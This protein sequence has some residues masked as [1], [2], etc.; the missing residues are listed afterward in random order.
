MLQSIRLRLLLLIKENK[1]EIKKVLWPTDFSG[2]A[3]HALT[4]VRSLSESEQAEIHVLYVITDFA[5]HRGLYGN[6][7]KE[8]REKIYE[9]EFKKAQERLDAICAQELAGCPLYIK[10]VA[11][12]DPAREIL[13]VA[14]SEG[15]DMIIMATRG[16]GK[17]FQMGV[18]AE[19]VAC[20][21]PI[22]VT[23][24]PTSG[25]A[26]ALRMAC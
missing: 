8:H 9:W 22:P 17:D 19:K 3:T 12:G 7:A 18:V 13:K 4:Y 11:V 25:E 24:V 16:T 21:S 5:H 23:M 6:F 26:V 10:H 14:Q 2:R 15:I 1:M 20:E